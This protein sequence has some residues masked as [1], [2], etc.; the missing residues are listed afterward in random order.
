MEVLGGNDLKKFFKFGCLPLLLLF[1]VIIVIAIIS[2][3][4]DKKDRESKKITIEEYEGRISQALKE[5]GEDT[6]LKIISNEEKNGKTVITLSEDIMLFLETEKEKINKATLGMTSSAYLTDK[7]DFDFAL[8][9]LVGTVDDSLSM[10]DRN[11]V[12]SELGLKDEKIFTE[13]NTEIY[14]NNDIRYT[15]SGSIKDNFLLEAEYK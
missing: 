11:K 15:Y 10:G 6:D 14:T 7:D 5:M 4:N 1:V 3:S 9:L 2:D 12:I 13:K 8:L